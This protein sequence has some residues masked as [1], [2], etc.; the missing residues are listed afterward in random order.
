MSAPEIIHCVWKRKDGHWSVCFYEHYRSLF[1][2]D[3]ELDYEAKRQLSVYLEESFGDFRMQLSIKTIPFMVGIFNTKKQIAFYSPRLMQELFLLGFLP[4]E[5]TKKLRQYVHQSIDL[6][7]DGFPSIHRLVAKQY[8]LPKITEDGEHP[9]DTRTLETI[10]I[11]KLNQY[12]PALFEYCTNHGLKLTASLAILRIHLLKFIA[13]LSSLD[14]DKKGREVKRMLLESLRRP[15]ADS[16]KA[17]KAKCEGEKRPLPLLLFLL[18]HGIKI[19]CHLLPAGL[20]AHLVRFGIRKMARRFIAGENMEEAKKS[21]AKLHESGRDATL[22]P[23]GE[24]VVSEQEACKYCQEVLSLIHGFTTTGEKNKAGIYKSHIS[25][26]VSALSSDFKPYAEDYVYQKTA[27]RLKKILLAARSRKVF[28]NIDAEHYSCRDLIFN[29]C[30]RVLLSTPELKDFAGVGMVIQAYLRDA[31]RSFEK[32]LKLAKQ[33]KVAMP[34]RLV[35]GA[36]WDAETV[37]AHAHGFDAPQ[38]LNKEET[39]LNFRQ[40]IIA[41]FKQ[42][43][44]LQLC[45]A[46]HNFSDHCYAVCVKNRYY[47]NLPPIEHQ[48]L[49]MTYEAL[50]VGMAQLNWV[51]RNYIPVGNLLV[52]MAYLVR[53]IMENS[54]QV[55]VLQI[56]LSHKKKKGLADP[57]HR[58]LQKT[59]KG[60]LQRDPTIH[61]SPGFHHTSPV[62]LYLEE[63]KKWMDESLAF[64]EKKLGDWYQNSLTGEILT[65]TSPS[66]SACVVGKIRLAS[67]ED[68]EQA[69]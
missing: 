64:G 42:W 66:D 6:P 45:L 26:K 44:H 35:K 36:Y 46:S 55:G 13:V 63:H 21:L 54:S 4:I 60:V 31:G 58:H 28:I 50:S 67:L 56:M 19:V 15:L 69:G 57:V 34:V 1:L 39:D 51:V 25:L 62:R 49:H 32:I 53:R 65:V 5:D 59:K 37:E 3:E 43:P 17:A 48:C 2:T 23:L 9:V 68:A 10:L 18:F 7:I 52:G 16:Q 61:P 30:R 29:I 14:F 24:L 8:H 20:L 33:R 38:F 40:L 27:P 11:Q 41:I 47:P 12:R 22:D